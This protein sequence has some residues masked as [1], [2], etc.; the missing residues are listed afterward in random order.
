MIIKKLFSKLFDRNT[1]YPV[2]LYPNTKQV[3]GRVLF[4]YLQNPLLFE[5][6]DKRLNKHS[7]NWESREIARLFCDLGFI[8]DAVNWR[9]ETFVPS[10]KYSVI[11]D[12][13]TNLQRIAPFLDRDTL[14]ILHITGSYPYYQNEE[15]M[16]RVNSLNIRRNEDYA[17][18]RQVINSDLYRRSIELSDACSLIG[19]EYTLNTFPEEFRNKIECVTVSSSY[20][21]LAEANLNFISK[22]REFLWFF[23][24][25]A[26]HK[27]LDLL[28][29]VFSKHRNLTLN[30]VGNVDF[31]K[32]FWE[33]YEYELTK[34]DNIRYHGYLDP[35]STEFK[36]IF[37][38]IFCFIAPSCS[39]GISP[40]VTTCMQLGLYPVI[41]RS[42]GVN[43]PAGFG[44]YLEECS[45]GEIE[46]AVLKVYNMRDADIK[47]QICKIKEY[48]EK[49]YS[50]KAFH[51][52][53]EN[54]IKNTLIKYNL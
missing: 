15:E 12:I 16:K 25:G 54:F 6:D 42:T 33:I 36:K 37:S 21:G 31:E 14:K 40:A 10:V 38:D 8:V 7:N 52:K 47:A 5:D 20:T 26:V 3:R 53:M 49:H 23:G 50:R 41:S 22:K 32:D 2:I 13:F 43:L 30:I 19:N 39:E 1:N 28:L 11:F 4:S 9:D 34:L 35:S 45:M 48:A 46:N 17:P 18:R 51:N 44:V 29:E 24:S 27:G